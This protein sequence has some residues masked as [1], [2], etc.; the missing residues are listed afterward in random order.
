MGMNPLI[1]C[2]MSFSVCFYSILCSGRG[3]LIGVGN[4]IAM[5]TFISFI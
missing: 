5:E 3:A 4:Q 1:C 2:L